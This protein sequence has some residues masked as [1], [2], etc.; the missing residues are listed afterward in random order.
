VVCDRYEAS[1]IAYQ[2]YA[3]GLDLERLWSANHAATGGLSPDLTIYLDIDPEAGLKRKLGEAEA[4]RTGLEDLDF[5]RLVRAGY[6]EQ[7]EAAPPNTWTRID[8]TL[9]PPQVAEAAWA[10]YQ[11]MGSR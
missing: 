10:A 8:A 3:R 4:I 6:L 9:P 2:G 11:R 1:F 5:H 7:M